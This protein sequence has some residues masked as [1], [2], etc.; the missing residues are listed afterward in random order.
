MN[1][2]G[3]RFLFPAEVHAGTYRGLQVAIKTIPQSKEDGPAMQ[4]FVQE[5]SIMT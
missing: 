2:R 4:S 1:G 5:A 3:F